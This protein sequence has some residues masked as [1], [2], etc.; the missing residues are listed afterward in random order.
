MITVL[1]KEVLVPLVFRWMGKL[2]SLNSLTVAQTCDELKQMCPL[3]QK[4]RCANQGV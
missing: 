2:W 4:A 3:T 1:N